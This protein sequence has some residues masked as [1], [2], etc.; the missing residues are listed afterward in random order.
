MPVTVKAGHSSVVTSSTTASIPNAENNTILWQANTINALGQITQSTLGSSLHRVSGYDTYHL[1]SQIQLKDGNTVIDHVD[2][3]FNP[4]TGNLTLR[5]DISNSRNEFFGYDA[6]NRLDTLR[7]N[8]GAFNRMTYYPGVLAHTILDGMKW[9]QTDT[10][11]DILELI[12]G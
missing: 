4:A 6:L 3:S 9:V 2:Y 10:L 5:N 11:K 12:M 1:P 7:L 8:S